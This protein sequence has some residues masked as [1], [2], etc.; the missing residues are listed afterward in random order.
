MKTISVKWIIG[1]AIVM[2]IFS[3]TALADGNRVGGRGGGAKKIQSGHGGGQG[4]HIKN[5]APQQ[6]FGRY[7]RRPIPPQGRVY[8]RPQYRPGPVP[9]YRHRPAPVPRYRYHPA[10]VPRYRYH[11]APVPR[12]RHLPARPYYGHRP[13]YRRPDAF[14]GFSFSILD[15]NFALGFST[16]GGW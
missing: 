2:F 5:K 13:Q 11:P 10:P 1:A 14:Y 9:R 4:P 6:K 12:Y 16:G 8:Q 3:G 7:Q 15:P